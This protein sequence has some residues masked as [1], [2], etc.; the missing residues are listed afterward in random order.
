MTATPTSGATSSSGSTAGTTGGSTTGPATTTAGTTDDTDTTTSDTGQ[1]IA[2]CDA[3]TPGDAFSVCAATYVGG[4]GVDGPRDIAFAADGALLYA[5]SLIGTDLGVSPTSLL[6]GGDGALLR[7]SADGQQLLSLTRIGAEVTGVAALPGG[8]IVIA[9]DFGVARLDGDAS[10]LLWQA[11]LGAT[12]S[13][14]RVGSDGTIAALVGDVILLDADGAEL[15]SVSTGGGTKSDLA[16]DGASQTV[17]VTGFKQEDGPPCTEL[18]IPFIRAYDYA[19]ASAWTAYDWT[20]EQVGASDECADSRGVALAIGGDGMLYYAGESHGGNTVHR[21][22]PNDLDEFAETVKF[23]KYNDPYNLNGAAPIAYYAR[24]DPATG[25]HERGQFLCTRLTSNDK[26]NAAR[27]SAIAATEDGSVI[28]SGGTACCVENG[29]SKTVNGE[30][31]FGEYLGGGFVLVV[32]PEFDERLSWTAFRGPGGNGE[33]GVRV[34]T[35]GANVAAIF[36]QEHED[37][38]DAWPM[39]T[40]NADAIAAAPGGGARDGWLT[41]FP[42]P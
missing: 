24:L 6:G 19:G 38:T 21:R 14:L 42:A 34:A 31:A 8:D 2:P 28:V 18:Q 26:G 7:V 33:T 30:P 40:F 36:E 16:I 3:F 22:L 25:A 1:A 27:P 13:R 17:M 12:P 39:L 32:S 20:K 5:G 15:A 41:L 10:T 37:G 11:E 29:D 9:G 23:D 4:A 35:N